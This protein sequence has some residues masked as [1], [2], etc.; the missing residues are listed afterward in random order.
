MWRT[1]IPLCPVNC[2]YKHAVHMDDD[3]AYCNTAGPSGCSYQGP[4][5]VFGV[6][7]S[8]VTLFQHCRVSST[9]TEA[10]CNA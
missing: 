6:S 10:R 2:L 1:S 9:D 5:S 3:S 7:G 8:V 4:V